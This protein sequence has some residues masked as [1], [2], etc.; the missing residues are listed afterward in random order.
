MVTKEFRDAVRLVG[1]K[2]EHK[3][4]KFRALRMK[5]GGPRFAAMGNGKKKWKNWILIAF[6]LIDNI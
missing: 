2:E 3:L 4:N 5:V 6:N 1:S